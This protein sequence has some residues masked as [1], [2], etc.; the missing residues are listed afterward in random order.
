MDLN[1]SSVAERDAKKFSLS[2]SGNAERFSAEYGDSVRYC[3]PWKKWLIWNGQR[4][5]PDGV[6][7]VSQLAKQTVRRMYGQAEGLADHERPRTHKARAGERIRQSSR[8]DGAIG[9]VRAAVSN[10]TG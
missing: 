9:E 4:W 7:E 3:H 8:G 1:E 2:D 6:D 5:A 10:F